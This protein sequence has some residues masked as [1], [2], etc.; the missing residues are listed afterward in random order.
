MEC[1]GMLSIVVIFGCFVEIFFLIDLALIGFNTGYY[2]K[3]VLIMNR[4]KISAN[5]LKGTFLLN[6]VSSAPIFLVLTTIFK[7]DLS[8][9]NFVT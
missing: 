6:L 5:Y 3:G 7:L 1:T 4:Q 9:S 2:D 8:M